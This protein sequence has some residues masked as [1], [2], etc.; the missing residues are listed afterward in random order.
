V[1]RLSVAQ[2][3][4][5]RHVLQRVDVEGGKGS[6]FSGVRAQ[7]STL[8]SCQAMTTLAEEPETGPS[9]LRHDAD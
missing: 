2:D 7:K 9:W 8:E 4:N 3:V 6:S 1:K 5:C